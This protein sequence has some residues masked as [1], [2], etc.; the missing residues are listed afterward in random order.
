MDIEKL[1]AI[2][3]ESDNIVFFGGAGVSTESAIPDFRSDRGLFESEFRSYSPE[4]ILSRRFMEARPDLF[5]AFYKKHMVYPDA[6]PNDAHRA[7]ARLEDR[8]QLRRIITQNI[9]GLHQKAGNKRVIEL[10]GCVNRNYCA[11]CEEKY[12]L[13]YVLTDPED[14]PKCKRCNGIVRPDVVLYGEQ[15]NDSDLS[16]AVEDISNADV[17][18]VAGTS[19]TVY[20]AAGLIQYYNG[21]KLILINRTPTRYDGLANYVISEQVGKVMKELVI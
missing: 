5:Y 12:S 6:R 15:L 16:Q 4:E 9:D 17:L 2:V 1:K 21:N 7:L 14:V 20:P 18:I 11:G 19:L 13:E 10:H 8:N 3:N